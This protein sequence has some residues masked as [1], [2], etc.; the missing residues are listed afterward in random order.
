M[1]RRLQARILGILAGCPDLAAVHEALP[2]A[3]EVLRQAVEGVRSG[4]VRSDEL[5]VCTVVSRSDYR[6]RSPTAVVATALRDEGVELLPGQKVRYVWG[7][8]GR[9]VPAGEADGYAPDR[10]TDLLLRSAGTL[11][12]PF[13]IPA[14]ELAR[15]LA[16]GGHQL[17]LAACVARRGR[18]R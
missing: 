15:R 3:V 2:G 10:Y 16:P 14:E 11:L 7:A 5:E 9:P 17:T 8:E 13:G 4:D 12:A 6:G 18:A 1:V